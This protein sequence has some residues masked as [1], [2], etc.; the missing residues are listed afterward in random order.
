MDQ[1]DTTPFMNPIIQGGRSLYTFIFHQKEIRVVLAEG[2]FYFSIPDICKSLKISKPSQSR[3]IDRDPDLSIGL[4]A[5]SLRTKGGPQPINCIH[6][7]QVH[8]WL[9]SIQSNKA[10]VEE[11]QQ[12]IRQVILQLAHLTRLTTPVHLPSHPLPNI[13]GPVVEGTITEKPEQEKNIHANEAE[14]R[15]LFDLVPTTSLKTTLVTTAYPEDRAIREA[16][17]ASRKQWERNPDTAALRFTS[18][19]ALQVYFSNPES[20]LEIPEAL[21][22]IR[23]QGETTALTARIVL[24][25]WTTRQ[26]AEI[27]TKTGSVPIKPAEI[28]EWRGVKKHNSKR[29]ADGYASNQKQRVHDDL[30]LLQQYYLRGHYE[31]RLKSGRIHN[32]LVDGP[33]LQMTVVKEQNLWGEE[34]IGYLVSPG[35]WINTYED[36]DI[37]FFAAVDRK[38]FQLNPQNQQHE[39]RLALYLTERWRQQ[40]KEGKYAEPITMHKLLEFSMI[41]IEKANFTNRFIPRIKSAL[42]ELFRLGILGAEP[43]CVSV[44]DMMQ[45]QWGKQW[46]ASEWILLPPKHLIND[47]ADSKGRKYLHT[48]H[49]SLDE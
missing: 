35:E 2:A 10:D 40:A 43:K 38:V 46:L 12:C 27:K 21:E 41:N 11:L 15:S 7:N 1:E 39:L 44:I 48:S 5:Y 42:N 47:Y 9:K 4:R 23:Q 18:S 32:I 13:T 26:E 16:T 31:M 33:Y 6:Q 29:Y 34:I 24:G 19:S 14:I 36:K 3:K 28:L 49:V 17:L 25:L 45:T 37:H 30:K 8:A 20:P 22:R